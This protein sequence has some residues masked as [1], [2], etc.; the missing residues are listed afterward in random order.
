MTIDLQHYAASLA[1]LKDARAVTEKARDYLQHWPDLYALAR[2]TAADY[3]RRH[4]GQWLDP[5]RVWWNVFDRAV[6]APTFTGW[7]HAGPPRE[8]IRFTDLLIQRF[9]GGFQAAPDVLPL[10]GGF[11]TQGRGASQYGA[12][13][14]VKLDPQKV[15]DDLWALDFASQVRQRSE[16]FWSEQGRDFPLLARVRLLASIETGVAEGRLQDLDRRRLKAYLRAPGHE[17]PTLD[18]AAFVVRHYLLEGSGHLLTLTASDGRVILYCPTT[19]WPPQAFAD[20]PALLA[21][22]HGQ[23]SAPLAHDWL[24]ALY[25]ADGQ[26]SAEELQK[27]LAQMRAR[28][29][30]A[31]APLWPFGEGRLLD[32][33]LFEELQAWARADLQVS[34]QALVSNGDLRKGLWRGYLGA[35]LQIVAPIAPA[36]WPLGLLVLGAGVARL[37]LDSQALASAHST[38]ERQEAILA[39][40]ADAVMVVFSLIDVGLSGRSLTYRAPPHERLAQPDSWAPVEGR[41]DEL[42]DLEAN[43]LVE[44]PVETDGL[45]RN[46]S[47]DEQGATWIEL[48]DQTLRVR[49]SPESDGWLAVDEDDPFAF[50]PGYPLRV[51]EEGS[52]QLFDVPQPSG[53]LTDGMEQLA[54]SFW[55]T[56]MRDNPLL[57]W[58]MSQTLL[59]AQRTTLAKAALPRIEPGAA[60]QT[61]ELGYECVEAG[62]QRHY[63]WR[64]GDEFQSQ[65]LRIYSSENSQVNNLFRHG[66]KGSIGEGDG[67]VPGY[68]HRLFD[69][70]DALPSSEAVR[71]WRGGSNYRLTG[72]VHYRNGDLNPGDVLVST[73]IT[74]FTENPYA[75]RAFVAPSMATGE[76]RFE[77]VFNETSVVYELVGKGLR[78][79]KPIAPMSLHPIES[80]VI[81]APGH[82][83]KIDSI[84]QVRGDHYH[85]VKVRLREVEKPMDEP[86]YDMRTGQ[87]FERLAFLERVGEEALVERLFPA[88]QWPTAR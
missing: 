33:D 12:H 77:S 83:F 58:E 65:L 50:L 72:G 54:S 56:Y 13:N 5:D 24:H 17:R 10:Y 68:L 37:V 81:Y 49:Y 53:V 86:I 25:R 84:R 66:V 60:L 30:S 67:D 47:V 26:S 87:P 85:F 11:Y 43:R 8:S 51:V 42:D 21:W 44:P 45:L 7:R 9:D 19:S 2:R 52:F 40:V 20:R 6:G 3:L 59:Q 29:G 88:E 48:Q 41:S 4:T 46:V 78:N 80:E 14:E 38:R 16:R 73:D 62:G 63:T 69:S 18:L 15:M 76:D 35:F 70:L 23:L 28:S 34:Q 55:D 71:L 31:E 27:A 82:F 75:L 32:T 36:A 61:D 74:S 1:S 57:Y 39:V 79:G 64:E 22:V